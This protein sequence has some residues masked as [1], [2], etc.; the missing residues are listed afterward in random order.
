[1]QI[2]TSATYNTIS[3]SLTAKSKATA[4]SCELACIGLLATI[5]VENVG[6]AQ[7]PSISSSIFS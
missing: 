5:V 3:V 6:Q 4:V 7:W 1:M 2:L